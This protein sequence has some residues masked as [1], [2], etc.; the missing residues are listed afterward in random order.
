M[1][2]SSNNKRLVKNTIFLYLRMLFL[3]C[4]GL[5]TS[6][7]LLRTLGADDYGLYNVVGGIVLMFGFLNATLSTS[8]Q[9]FLNIEL[10]KKNGGN[11][12]LVFSTS[13]LLHFLLLLIVLF[14]AETVGLWY[15]KEKLVVDAGRELAAMFVY[16]FSVVAI[17]IQIIQLPFMS[18]IIAHERMNIYAY[19]SLFEGIAKLAVIFAI[20]LLPYDNLIMYA[21][22]ILCVQISVAIIYNIYCHRNFKEA[23]FNLKYEKGIFSEMLGFSGWNIIGN[24][25][26]AC[27]SQGLNILMNAFGGTIVN[28]ARGIAF[29]VHGLVQQLVN[30]FQLAVKPQVIKYYSS[31]QMEE[32]VNLVFN[33]AKYSAFLMTVA[34]VPLILEIRPLLT[35]WL[36]EYPEHTVIFVQLILFRSVITS[37]TGNIVMVVHASGYLKRVGIFSGGILL[38]VLPTSYFMLKMGMPIYI[39]F[40]VNIG[41]AIGEAFFELYWMRHYIGFPMWDF[42]KRV[43]LPVFILLAVVLTLS[44]SVHILLA[45][46]NEYLRMVIVGLFSVTLSLLLIYRFG[47]SKSMRDKVSEKILSRF[48]IKRKIK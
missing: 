30:N 46:Y 19:V 25:A 33:A 42:Y 17:C 10:G 4:I 48:G 23:R 11:V 14:L 15:V 21:F 22:L 5:Y 3:T 20:Q 32:M 12:K 26:S 34:S 2:V 13:L 7:V 35:L 24:L 28:A 36:G 41:G 31:G 6:R 45:D 9:R 29:Q 38:L 8:T 27:N 40:I 37:M 1:N 44:Y 16:Q 18:T 39:P 43:Y 47:L